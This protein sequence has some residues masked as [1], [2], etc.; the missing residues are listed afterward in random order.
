MTVPTFAGRWDDGS[1]TVQPPDDTPLESEV[2]NIFIHRF[3]RDDR[4]DMH[5]HPWPNVSLVVVG[6]YEEDTPDGPRVRRP[7]D[8]VI[9]QAEQR[10]AITR[11]RPGTISIFLTGRKCRDWGFWPEID[12]VPTFILHREYR[13]WLAEQGRR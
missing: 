11:V 1:Q 7:G 5:C 12:G 4:E 3:T 8:I 10:H 6:E 13:A 2:E 9:R